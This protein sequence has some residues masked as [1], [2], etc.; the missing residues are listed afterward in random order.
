MNC[1]SL[2][3]YFKLKSLTTIHWCDIFILEIPKLKGAP[4][5]EGMNYENLQDTFCLDDSRS[6][7]VCILIREFTFLSGYILRNTALL[8]WQNDFN[9][10]TVYF[11]RFAVA[12]L[13]LL[14]S[15]T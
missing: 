2:I 14:V 8:L 9:D 7:L 10:Q 5:S 15:L 6:S 11:I 12:S 4:D 3:A 1:I 13:V